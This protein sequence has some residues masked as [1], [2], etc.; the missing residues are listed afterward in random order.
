MN[1]VKA[2]TELAP[3][4][5]WSLA[6]DTLSGLAWLDTTTPRPKDAVIKAKIAEIE[7]R[8]PDLA[9]YRFAIQTHIDATARAR[10]YD[11]GVTCV[12]YIGSTTP[13]WAA[14]AAAFAAWRDAVWAYAYGVMDRVQ[15]GQREQPPVAAL[16]AELPEIRWP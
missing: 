7:A 8:P 6:G 16:L 5:A 12:S 15:T 9:E 14:E 11:S 4:A 1:L 3:G 13:A 10:S 2:L